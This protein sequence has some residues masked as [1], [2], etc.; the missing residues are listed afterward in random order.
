MLNF[1]YRIKQKLG[2]GGTGTVYLC[3][4]VLRG[5]ALRA[6]KVLSLPTSSDAASFETFRNEVS[7]LSS[8][9]HPHLVTLHDL[10]TIRTSSD[11]PDLVG[12]RFF[13]MEYVRGIES[14]SWGAGLPT[15][16][17]RG[18]V[19]EELL[20]QSLSVLGYIHQEGI[21]HFDIKPENLLVTGEPLA[22]ILKLLDFGFSGSAKDDVATRACGTLEYT[23]PEI[24]RGETADHRVD[25]YSLGACFFHIVEGHPPFEGSTPIEVI[26]RAITEPPRFSHPTWEAMPSL[27]RGVELLL[28]KNPEERADSATALLRLIS[29]GSPSAIA[30]QLSTLTPAGLVGRGGEQQRV[31]EAIFAL[32]EGKAASMRGSLCVVGPEGSGKTR[33]L[34]YAIQQARSVDLPVFVVERTTVDAGPCAF[35]FPLIALRA[36]AASRGAGEDE[37]LRQMWEAIEPTTPGSFSTDSAQRDPRADMVARRIVGF[38]LGCAA[39]FPFVIA[40]DDAETLDS[41]SREVLRI[42]LR[43]SAGRPLVITTVTHRSDDFPEG[44]H[45][46]RLHLQEL[47]LASCTKL[48]ATCIGHPPTLPVL[49][50][51]IYDRFGGMPGIVL[52]AI[53]ILGKR[54]TRHACEDERA[55]TAL[56][57]SSGLFSEGGLEGLLVNR[58]LQSSRERQLVLLLLSCFRSAARLDVLHRVLPFN[59]DRWRAHTELLSLEGLVHQS[60]HGTCVELR[61]QH[62]KAT[63]YARLAEDRVSLHQEIAKAIEQCAESPTGNDL[64]ELGWQLAATGQFIRSVDCYERAARCFEDVSATNGAITALTLAVAS[65]KATREPSRAVTLSLKLADTLRRGKKFQEARDTAVQLLDEAALDP[66]QRGLLHN[67]IG[68]S[69]SRLGNL[70]RA[71]FHLQNAAALL[72]SPA[73]RLQAQQEITSLDIREGRFKEAE[74]NGLR[75]LPQAEALDSLRL[76]ALILNDLGIATFFQDRYDDANAYF[77]RAMECY[78]QLGDDAGT[79]DALI[80]IGNTQSARGDPRSAIAS[81]GDACTIIESKGAPHQLALIQNNMGIAHFNLR[82]FPAARQ[83]Y[84][85]A[86]EL[87]TQLEMQSGL[88]Y[89]HANFGE[90]E[91]SEGH[92]EAS[93][94]SWK[95]A[96][97]LYETSGNFRDIV[98]SSIQLARV[99][100]TIG[101]VSAAEDVLDRATAVASDHELH[102]MAGSLELVRSLIFYE[103]QQYADAATSVGNARDL[104][105]G[106]DEREKLLQCDLLRCQ[107]AVMTG[108]VTPAV[109]DLASLYEST[110]DGKTPAFAAEALF[111]IGLCARVAP[112][113]WEEKPVV[114]FK[115]CLSMLANEPVTEL[116]WEVLVQLAGELFE[117]GQR[118]RAQQYLTQAAK[119]LRYF[120]SQFTSPDLKSLYLKSHGR[121]RAVAT[122]RKH[123]SKATV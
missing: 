90:L 3:E 57:A 2:E 45:H 31:A 76:Q 72:A 27:R 16:P 69:E 58:F 104:L 86:R 6:L 30:H 119:V 94:K 79:A 107:C 103:K 60:E 110:K 5:R 84:L 106:H 41:L 18:K 14:S 108:D 118:E 105:R 116:T 114:L 88:A 46:I 112:Q 111:R 43:E 100:L 87:C 29:A 1:R 7:V 47:D 20:L 61:H 52:Q 89:T 82:E 13:T 12:R 33:L 55:A 48:A 59:V 95:E 26:K 9:A 91:A 64:I 77:Q 25:L 122:I 38:L 68:M 109:R 73:E 74:E 51:H 67:V 8:L 120:A 83:C 35:S 97:R 99:Y 39:R 102:S 121:D 117:R 70:E 123:L 63:L 98:E 11:M 101:D 81:W 49:C 65:A 21:I 22:P 24:L 113:L 36:E 66:S 42:A 78:K 28:T 85:R 10:G 80:N 56:L 53:Q 37:H 115:K 54:L 32:A 23:A 96:K 34:K 75:H 62:L 71:L 40:A 19:I 15:G 93:L 17:I 4:D 50:R 92:Y 44:P